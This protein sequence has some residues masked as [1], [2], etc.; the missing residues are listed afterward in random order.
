MF[1]VRKVFDESGFMV[2]DQ[3]VNIMD[4]IDE[5]LFSWFT[6]NFLLSMFFLLEYLLL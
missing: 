3:S 5:G 6:I 4:G 1:K 2:T